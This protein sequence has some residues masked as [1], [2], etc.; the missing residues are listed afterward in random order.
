MKTLESLLSEYRKDLTLEQEFFTSSEVFNADVEHVWMKKWLFTGFTSQIPNVGDYFVYDFLKDSIVIIRG[1]DNKVYAHHNTCRHR[2]SVICTEKKGN[3][4]FLTCPYH[5]WIYEKNGDLRNARMMPEGFDKTKFGLHSVSL[6]IV[7]GVIYIYLSD[8]PPS[9][10]KM[11]DEL[12][13]FMK[14]YQFGKAKVAHHARYE[15]N[16]NWKLIAENFRECYHCGPTHPEY[17]K[18]IDVSNLMEDGKR[19]A[20]LDLSEKKWAEKGMAT[21]TV[22]FREDSS[23]YAIRYPL[24]EGFK[25]YSLDG[26]P[27]SSV[28]GSHQDYDNG[29][30]GLVTFPNCW[31]DCVSDYA[32]ALRVTPVDA[33]HC[34]AD[35]YF[36]VD[37]DAVEG[38][39]YELERLTAFWSVT[40]QQDWKAIENNQKGIESRI[41]APGP[42]ACPEID[43]SGFDQWYIDCLREGQKK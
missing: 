5:S 36:M 16:G 26:E 35:S 2:G 34:I 6:E 14:P 33:T 39:D 38:K 40:A 22:E 23:H 42:F 24:K 7:E 28:M 21:D 13:P 43:T 3:T 25:S 29:V 1:D 11:R 12:G 10:D 41:Y 27:V 8:N 31:M 37:A 17:C 19:T 30:V 15:L 20:Y 18:A 32:W 4:K 9:F